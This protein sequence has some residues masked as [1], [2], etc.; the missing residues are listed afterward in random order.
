MQL[1][2]R[3]GFIGGAFVVVTALGCLRDAATT[4]PLKPARAATRTQHLEVGEAGPQL[5]ATRLLRR[6]L[7]TL[8]G[9]TPTMSEL[10]ALQ[11]LPD[12]AAREQALLA[13]VDASLTSLAFYQQ[14][15]TY[16]HD[17]LRTSRYIAGNTDHSFWKGDL[18]A[19]I[20]PCPAG[21][22]HAGVYGKL[23]EDYAP[24]YGDKTSVVCND[25]QAT[26]TTLAPWWQPTTTVS[27]IGRAANP[28]SFADGE[29]CGHI[30][31]DLYGHNTNLN[32]EHCGCGPA[33]HFCTLD[34]DAGPNQDTTLL[35]SRQ[36]SAW[37]QPARFFAHLAW[38]DRDLSDLVLADYTVGD[39]NMRHMDWRFGRQTLDNNTALD[40]EPNWWRPESWTTPASPDVAAADV[41]SWHEYRLED[42]DPSRPS[43]D[44]F[45]DPRVDNGK[46]VGMPAA[47]TLTMMATMS[48]FPRERVRGA[49]ALEAFA[50]RDFAPP[51]PEVHFPAYINDPAQG[52]P[53][54]QC[55]TLI[56]PASIHFKRWGFL[57]YSGEP[58]LAGLSWHGAYA[59]HPV[60]EDA[61]KRWTEVLIPDTKLT[62]VSAAR[63]AAFPEARFIDFLPEDQTL[64]GLTSDGTIG[65]RG[66]AK[67]VVQSGELD[68]CMTRRL[69]ERFTGEALQPGKDAT[70]IRA[71]TETFIAGGRQVRPFVRAV[72]AQPACFNDASA[73]G[74]EFFRGL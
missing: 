58:L 27:L 17:L 6:M 70:R 49:R 39:L 62:P 30:S 11:A 36:R 57:G 37:E 68:A 38:H 16:G 26:I 18:T 24:S 12:A 69:Y 73:A 60:Y 74:C 29:D 21:T 66:F 42:L 45:F 40:A 4:E 13:Q 72:M 15:V 67:L 48:S 2:T 59:D 25:A 53:C 61:Y 41:L 63:I 10:E 34:V 32:S 20:S 52:G 31:T 64:F 5:P 50:C 7:V 23:S 9:R 71:L 8:E 14:M 22:L 19:V 1:H 44:V 51:P 3:L 65:P 43:A 56:D 35:G 47:G 28:A 54:M 46:P 55:H 33:A